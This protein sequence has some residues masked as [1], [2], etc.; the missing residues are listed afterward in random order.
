MKIIL[1]FYIFI[2]LFKDQYNATETS[3]E[4][5]S[6]IPVDFVRVIRNANALEGSSDGSAEGS[7]DRYK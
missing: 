6:L 2:I 5:F 3:E 7:A 4:M 1:Y